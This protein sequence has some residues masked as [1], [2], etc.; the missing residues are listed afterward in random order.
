MNALFLYFVAYLAGG[1]PTLQRTATVAA[2]SALPSAVKALVAGGVALASPHVTP[3]Q[4]DGLVRFGEVSGVLMEPL[5]RIF[6][7]VDAFTLWTYLLLW[8]GLA[9]A[10]QIS[11]GRAAIAVAT[12]FVVRL[13]VWNVVLG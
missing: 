6:H 8:F 11:R 1:K 9:E 4:V 12:V 3:D 10:A 7:G 5:S 13:L 2:Y